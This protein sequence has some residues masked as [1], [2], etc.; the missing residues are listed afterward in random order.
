MPSSLQ[1]AERR[2]SSLNS[3][4]SEKSGSKRLE[5]SFTSKG[6]SQ[7]Q[8]G[9]EDLDHV[10]IPDDDN[11]EGESLTDDGEMNEEEEEVDQVQAVEDPE[12]N[13]EVFGSTVVAA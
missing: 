6:H 12:V 8:Q 11:S 10:D 2:P 5:E 7:V 9:L 13:T 4:H 1:G 3:S